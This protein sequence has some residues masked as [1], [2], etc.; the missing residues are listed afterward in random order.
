MKEI[1]LTSE[2][3]SVFKKCTGVS[4]DSRDIQDGCIYFA[5]KGANFNGNLFAEEA[6]RKGASYAVVDE[7][8]NS[9]DV[10]I[11]RVENCLQA[12][13]DLARFHRYK[14]KI[15]VIGI[16]GSNGKTT[17]KEL[18]AAILSKKLNTYFTPGN[19]NNH[20]GVP[21]SVLEIDEKH[22]IAVIEMGANHQGEIAFLC[23]I[24]QPSHG[25][26]TNIGKAHLEGFGGIEGVKKGK[27]ELY[28][29]LHHVQGKVF[30]N[31]DDQILTELTPDLELIQYGSNKEFY[32]QGSLY[33]SQPNI[34]GDW[35]C[36]NQSGLIKSPLFGEYNFYNILAAICIGNYFGVSATEINEAISHY[37]STNNR[38]QFIQKENFTILLDAYNANP[39]SMQKAI[40]NFKGREANSKVAVLGDMFELGEVSKEEHKKLIHLAEKQNFDL[41]VFVG[42][43]F[44][45]EQKL[46][47]NLLFL[48][49]TEEAVEWFRNFDKEGKEFLIKGSRGMALERLLKNK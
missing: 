44:I 8:I 37:N 41:C 32:C 33:K 15:P 22:D 7:D 29:F 35:I 5:L 19:L 2:L 25:L 3:Y 10:R 30:L 42:S 12:L 28:K 40:E 49:N 45:L 39:T 43:Q 24:S 9:E 21:L 38:S 14:L 27:S 16:T 48:A 26:I 36:H 11:L 4:K 17:T 18:I 31:G 6:L 1:T 34:K 23:T 13:Q 46:A 47:P 20:I